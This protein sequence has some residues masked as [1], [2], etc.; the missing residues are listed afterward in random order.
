MSN[1]TAA[2]IVRRLSGRWELV[3][4]EVIGG[5]DTQLP[6]GDT[7]LGEVWYGPNRHFTGQIMRSSDLRFGSDDIAQATQQETAAAFRGYLAYFGTFEVD[8]SA[9]EIIHRVRA[10]LF[11]N[12]IGSN[13]RRRVR[14]EG[15]R[16]ILETPPF[17][18]EGTDRR[19]RA[20]WKRGA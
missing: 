14:F 17:L 20:V 3:S 11:P 6:F 2:D 18:H 4:V 19:F 13:Q 5:S 9:Q 10:S 16:L 12:W 1:L 15:E 7:P 8:E